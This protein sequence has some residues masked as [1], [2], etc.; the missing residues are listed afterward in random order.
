MP[1]LS[2]HWLPYTVIGSCL[3]YFHLR[4]KASPRHAGRRATDE[5]HHA[6]TIHRAVPLHVSAEVGENPRGPAAL[7]VAA[8]AA[9]AA[10]SITT[11]DG[12]EEGVSPAFAFLH[13][14]VLIIGKLILWTWVTKSPFVAEDAALAVVSGEKRG[15]RDT[16]ER[17]GGRKERTTTAWIAWKQSTAVPSSAAKVV[18]LP[19]QVHTNHHTK[20]SAILQELFTSGWLSYVGEEVIWLDLLLSGTTYARVCARAGNLGR[21]CPPDPLQV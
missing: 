4:Q 19:L 7:A 16:E 5:G 12:D 9:V 15:A 20:S 17:L 2:T 14:A 18:S 11:A 8:V 3:I 6:V 1:T 13:C 21:K 10:P